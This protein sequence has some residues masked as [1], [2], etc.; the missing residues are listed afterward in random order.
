MKSRRTRPYLRLWPPRL[1]PGLQPNAL[2]LVSDIG[3]GLLPPLAVNGTGSLSNS[4][5]TITNPSASGGG[6][7][8]SLQMN[9][10]FGTGFTGNRVVSGGAGRAGYHF[11]LAVDEE[12]DG[13]VNPEPFIDSTRR[14]RVKSRCKTAALAV[15]ERHAESFD[16]PSFM[17]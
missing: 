5:C 3:D 7:T 14:C 8:L 6:N 16:K 2:Y 17:R 10:A 4:Q 13:P 12:L 15:S 11:R 9:I 1:L